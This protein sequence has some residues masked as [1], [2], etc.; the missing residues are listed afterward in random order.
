MIGASQML[1]SDPDFSSY[2]PHGAN[3]ETPSSRFLGRSYEFAWLWRILEKSL[4]GQPGLAVITGD[5]G[6]GKSRLI[7]EF[8]AQAKRMGV[9]PGFGRGHQGQAPPYQPW[10][11]LSDSIAAQLPVAFST[12]MLLR[13]ESSE[14]LENHHL[15][16]TEGQRS[17]YYGQFVDFFMQ[18][19]KDTPI[20]LVVDDFHWL[21]M[22]SLEISTQLLVSLLDQSLYQPVRVMTLIATRPTPSERPLGRVLSRLEREEAHDGLKLS[23]LDLDTVAAYIKDLGILRPSFQFTNTIYQATKGNPLFVK[24]SVRQLQQRA[25][26]E[27]HSGFAISNLSSNDIELPPDLTAAIDE[28]LGE[29]DQESDKL[30][31]FAAHIGDEFEVR[32]LAAVSELAEA[33][34]VDILESL[35]HVV[36]CGDSTYQFEHPLIQHCLYRRRKPSERRRLHA[37]IAL[38]LEEIDPARSEAEPWLVAKHLIAAGRS[39]DPEK[40][41]KYAR[42]AAERAEAVFAWN[43]AAYAYAAAASATA[44][45]CE[46]SQLHLRAGTCFRYSWD[47]GPC[48]AQYDLAIQGFEKIGEHRGVAESQVHRARQLIRSVPIGTVP[49]LTPFKTALGLVGEDDLALRG[50]IL[51]RLSDAYSHGRSNK[52]AAAAARQALVLGERIGDDRLSNDA[53]TFLGLAEHQLGRVE[54]AI[55][56]YRK[57]IDH[58]QRAGDPWLE[59]IPR[60]RLTLS[61]YAMGDLKAA[62]ENALRGLKHTRQ[63]RYPGEACMALAGLAKLAVVTGTFDDCQQYASDGLKAFQRSRYSFGAYIALRALACARSWLG[64]RDGANDAIEALEQPERIF[65]SPGSWL[66]ASCRLF[67]RYIKVI[68][69][70]DENSLRSNKAFSK[71]KIVKHIED[72]SLKSPNAYTITETCAIIEICFILQFSG[73]D[74]KLVKNLEW[75]RKNKISFTHGWVFYVP[76]VL[77]SAYFLAG[78]T[79]KATR[80]L[81][82]VIAELQKTDAKTELA[83]AHHDLARILISRSE[84]QEQKAVHSLREA[85]RLFRALGMK[86]WLLKAQQLA[87]SANV[88]IENY[89][90]CDDVEALPALRQR[91]ILDCLVRGEPFERIAEALVLSPRTLAAESRQLAKKLGTLPVVGQRSIPMTIM[92]TDLEK[93]TPMLEGLGDHRA[94]GI[95]RIHDLMVRACMRA[96]GGNEIRHSGDGFLMSFDSAS[97]AVRCA[98]DVQRA[99]EAY[100]ADSKATPMRIRIGVHSGEVIAGSEGPFGLALHIASRICDLCEP[101]KVLVSETTSLNAIEEG[102]TCSN[103]GNVYLK[104]L[105]HSI[106]LYDV[107]W[108]Q[109]RA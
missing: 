98:C 97:S 54:Q 56:H 50:Y 24:A 51:V 107:V 30:L 83:R 66:K 16:E 67:R 106:E 28:Q 41:S 65:E 81:R 52:L 7:R 77:A 31:T 64:D 40:T 102:V 4:A 38:K 100:N 62:K 59:N 63:T 99:F 48:V 82:R 109:D 84:A 75:A 73:F 74:K 86:S 42:L 23:G 105:T 8:V 89:D 19:Q 11:D 69:N 87:H 71:K 3:L 13:H 10:I 26:I 12:S 34:I 29:L 5:A 27:S 39:A 14:S 93:S 9:V 94:I 45:L 101:G 72:L 95:M 2:K 15:Y 85:T 70:P 55:T 46:R 47:Q 20:L 88:R 80:L 76:R 49:D 44:D 36:E 33:S 17:R 91:S 22:P 108:D 92:I 58:A 43:D 90:P 103:V 35:D 96:N 78:D 60:Q 53:C 25:K 18:V 79:D 21:D 6:I 32:D 104:G 1:V 68:C 57:A 37:K 61:L